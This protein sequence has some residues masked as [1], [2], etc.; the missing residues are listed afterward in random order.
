MTPKCETVDSEASHALL[1]SCLERN[2]FTGLWSPPTDRQIDHVLTYRARTESL[3]HSGAEIFVD[4]AQ[5]G[6][7]LG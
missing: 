2:A 4:L 5:I 1:C 3:G 7:P 6:E